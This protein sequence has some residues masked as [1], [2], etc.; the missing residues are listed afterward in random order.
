MLPS[1][2]DSGVILISNLGFLRALVQACIG[3]VGGI[4]TAVP[5]EWILRNRPR[6]QDS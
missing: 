4:I 6:P 3:L 1:L 2:A 5:L